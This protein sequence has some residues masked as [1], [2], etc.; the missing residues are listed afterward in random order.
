MKYISN[1]ELKEVAILAFCLGI[2]ESKKNVIFIDEKHTERLNEIYEKMKD[3]VNK[4][5]EHR[6]YILT[7]AKR[8]LDTVAKILYEKQVHL[9]LLALEMLFITF[10]SNERGK[11]LS[12][13]L[14]KF[15]N[16]VK[17]N[18]E[19]LTNRD[20]ENILAETINF[21]YILKGSVK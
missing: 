21:A 8:Y 5:K 14:Q 2:L 4:Y 3:T 16:D 15:W 9:T 10:S 7:K 11:P 19:N 13:T 6:K 18:V 20:Y 1:G 12:N 17:S